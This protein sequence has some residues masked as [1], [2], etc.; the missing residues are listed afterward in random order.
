MLSLWRLAKHLYPIVVV[1]RGKGK[2]SSTAKGKRKSEEAPSKK[3]SYKKRTPSAV[4]ERISTD[5]D[6]DDFLPAKPIRK[7][8]S[9]FKPQKTM[10]KQNQKKSKQSVKNAAVSESSDL[11]SE[12]ELSNVSDTVSESG[13]LEYF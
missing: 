2:A 5:A 11:S 6:A 1:T 7:Q 12:D 10:D 9:V 4:S 8:K 3:R 13:I